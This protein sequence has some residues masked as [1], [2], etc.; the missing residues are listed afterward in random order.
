HWLLAER[1]GEENGIRSERMFDDFNKFLETRCG[2]DAKIEKSTFYRC[3]SELAEHNAITKVNRGH[4]FANPDLFWGDDIEK[5][6]NH[7]KLANLDKKGGLLRITPDEN[8]VENSAL[9]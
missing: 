6:I 7:L 9:E 3:I 2:E 8:N 4:Y 1:I 5:R